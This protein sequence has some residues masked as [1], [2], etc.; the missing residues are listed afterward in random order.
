M[1]F[2]A[3]VSCWSELDNTTL[4]ALV[5][6]LNVLIDKQDE[7]PS[8]VLQMLL[9]L[10]QFMYQQS[11]VNMS[12]SAVILRS[13]NLSLTAIATLAEACHSYPQALWCREKELRT[14]VVTTDL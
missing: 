9:W 12:F 3:F 8:D 1:F 14:Y 7:L 2:P 5:G 6:H 10:C 11:T 13:E 4:V